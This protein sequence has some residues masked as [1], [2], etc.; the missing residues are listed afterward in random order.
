MS[1]LPA[2]KVAVSAAGEGRGSRE[3]IDDS[4]KTESTKKHERFAN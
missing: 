2:R 3:N 1:P 4:D